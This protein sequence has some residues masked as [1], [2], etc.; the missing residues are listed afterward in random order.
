MDDSRFNRIESKLDTLTDSVSELKIDV[1]VV[2]ATLNEHDARGVK[3]QVRADEAY[4][5]AEEAK[6]PVVF[7]TRIGT[8]SKW[9]GWVGG[10]TVV[11]YQFIMWMRG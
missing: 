4:A 8:L 10:S 7:L 2:Q 11:I 5:K 3:A 1:R 9:V 6:A